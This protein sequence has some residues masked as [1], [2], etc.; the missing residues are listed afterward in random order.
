M[1]RRHHERECPL[2]IHMH[3]VSRQMPACQVCYACGKYHRTENCPI[4]PPE[5]GYPF[6]QGVTMWRIHC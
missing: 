2:S 5:S 3:D 6:S 1:L 4:G